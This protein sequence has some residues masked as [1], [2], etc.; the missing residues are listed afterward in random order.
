MKITLWGTRG[1]LASPGPETARYGGNTSCVEVRGGDGTVLVL[2]AG[3]GIRRLGATLP[4]TLRRVDVLLTHLHM[5]HIQGLGFFAPL[6]NPNV[7]VHIWGPA[8]VTLGLRARLSR[9]LSPPLFPVHLRDM[10]STVCLHEVPCAEFDVGEFHIN[11]SLVCHPD[12]TVGYRIMTP[13][14]VVVYLPDHEPALGAQQFPLSQDWTSGCALA[15]NADLLIHDA[16]Y[17][18]Q[19]Y[20]DRVGFGHSSLPQAF[21]FGALAGVK[22]FVPFHHDPAHSDDDLDRLIAETVTAVKPP[23]QITP[24]AEGTTF[25]LGTA[26]G[27]PGTKGNSGTG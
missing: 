24:G 2:D 21:E 11:S 6:R 1:S 9:Y 20:E 26:E 17:T 16:Q 5:D 13:D 10:P 22:H 7:E 15:E 19:E 12:P 4:K 27:T 23:F 3:T 14:G 18:P 25:A 8:S